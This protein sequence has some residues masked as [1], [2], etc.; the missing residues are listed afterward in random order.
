MRRSDTVGGTINVPTRRE[1]ARAT[2]L[3]G[4]ARLVADLL[5]T[6]A[7]LAIARSLGP[8]DFGQLS[9]LLVLATG[10]TIV[11]EGGGQAASSHIAA[12]KVAEARRSLFAALS[13]GLLLSQVTLVAVVAGYLGGL[14]LRTLGAAS[15]LCLLPLQA[16]LNGTLTG[17]LAVRAQYLAVGASQLFGGV[18]YLLAVALVAWR[19]PSVVGFVTCVVLRQF[20]TT[21]WLSFAYGKTTRTCRAQVDPPERASGADGF[22]RWVVLARGLGLIKMNMDY[23][24]LA[25]LASSRELGIYAL[26]FLLSVSLVFRLLPAL[27]QSIIPLITRGGEDLVFRS[28]RAHLL[29]TEVLGWTSC[30]LFIGLALTSRFGVLDRLGHSWTSSEVLGVL[31]LT[32]LA[33]P[34]DATTDVVLI[35]ARLGKT[36]ALSLLA[37]VGATALCIGIVFA[38]NPSAVSMAWAVVASTAASGAIGEFA[39]VRALAVSPR[40]VLRSWAVP[41]ACLLPAYGVVTVAF[42]GSTAHLPQLLV[43]ALRCAAI[44]FAVLC[45]LAASVR[46][47]AIIGYRPSA[48]PR[49]SRALR[50]MATRS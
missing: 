11:A 22:R 35:G 8:A 7:S 2:S 20:A 36:L 31:S 42:D 46:C 13:S 12:S 48:I 50:E 39:V 25:V 28:S 23:V 16:G 26:A 21:A 5:I 9:L 37:Q 43:V 17:L 32:L 49:P 15:I 6:A 4:G 10:L 19:F 47:L 27:Q 45:L 1:A 33:R 18:T 24:V 34:L 14:P 38:P 30:S 44:V 3:I 29:L 40:S 41:Y